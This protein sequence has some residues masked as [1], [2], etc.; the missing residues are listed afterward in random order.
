MTVGKYW[1]TLLIC[2]LTVTLTEPQELRAL[3]DMGNY[4]EYVLKC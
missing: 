3:D 2:R 4:H 1:R